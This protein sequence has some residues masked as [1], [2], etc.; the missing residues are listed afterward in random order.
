MRNLKLLISAIVLFLS[1]NTYGQTIVHKKKV[2]IQDSLIV[3]GNI[4]TTGTLS[5]TSASFSGNVG[6][7]TTSSGAKLDASGTYRL[8][9]R[10]DDAIPE[11]RSI[12]AD[13]TAFKELGLNGSE[14]ILKTS[15][16]ERMRITSAGD[17]TIT[18]DV[19]ANNLS[20]ANTGD[21]DLSPYLTSA[22]AATTYLPLAGGTMTGGI[23][24]DASTPAAAF[25]G[26]D[27]D[28]GGSGRLLSIGKNSKPWGTI[29][30][31]AE[32]EQAGFLFYSMGS[33]TNEVAQIDAS[34]SATFDS[35]KSTN[36]NVQTIT[37]NDIVDGD[38]NVIVANSSSAITITIPT[39]STLNSIIKVCNIGTGDVGYAAASGVTI[40]KMNG[41]YTYNGWTTELIKIGTN[42]W[43]ITNLNL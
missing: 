30:F 38:T 35:V 9:L 25:I 4:K 15:S 31:F 32:E 3:S 36:N 40:T 19:S 18:G 28:S 29:A 7:G 23:G 34:G 14:L 6:I 5:G 21:Q 24:F 16:T 42:E 17:V 22:I 2:K 12:T 8:Q 13:G 37:S 26:Q 43:L 27:A 1:V 20:G 41:A 39:T 11:L 10:T 33:T